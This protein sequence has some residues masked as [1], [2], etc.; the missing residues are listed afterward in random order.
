MGGTVKAPQ[1]PTGS[2][3]KCKAPAGCARPRSWISVLVLFVLF[4]ARA[5][6]AGAQHAL[7]VQT[8][9]PPPGRSSAL[10]IPDP[11]LPP[12]GTLL[13]GIG[14]HYASRPLTRSIDCRVI[15]AANA[16]LCPPGTPLQSKMVLLSEL[17]QAELSVGLSLFDALQLGVVVPAVR[18]TVVDNL[19][20]PSGFRDE[21]GLGDLRLSVDYPLLRGDTALALGMVVSLP[22]GA[23]DTLAAARSWT[24]QPALVLSQRLK[25]LV[26]SLALGY[27]MRERVIRADLEY[28]DEL[29]GALGVALSV[30]DPLELRAELRARVGVGGFTVLP[31]QNPVELDA[32]LGLRATPRWLFLLGAGSG[33]WPGR[34]GYGAPQLRLFGSVRWE[35]EPVPCEHGA[36]DFDAYRDGDFCGDPDNDADGRLDAADT[37][38]NDAEDRDGFEDDDGCPDLDNDADGLLDR[39][40]QCAQASE[41]RDGF[42]DGDGCPE[43]DNDADGLAD[44]A[45]GCALD[46]EDRDDFEDE[47]GCPEPGPKEVSVS[48]EEQRILVSERIYFDDARDTIREVSMPVLDEVAAA[49][50]KLRSS[51]KVVVEGH[52]DDAGSSAYNLDLSHRR[53][54]AVV[55]YLRARG[56]AAERLDY[57]GYGATR[58]LGPNDSPEGRALNR[59]VEFTLAR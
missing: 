17:T 43:P 27:H 32:A 21:H 41:D 57:V 55:E 6:T 48:V 37:C 42:E 19:E 52:T 39:M 56:V 10:T 49:I 45:D 26:L 31:N 12:H 46:P 28:D 7:D 2:T 18:S 30:I 44:A 13:L 5:P 50:R 34:D 11:S 1:T 59:R 35:I 23:G 14:V 53:A 54:R 40:D 38:P 36:E 16:A 8:F 29:Q 3:A 25:P 58:P 33:I 24:L 20:Q 15:D 47:D 4:V 9:K 51:S 22:T